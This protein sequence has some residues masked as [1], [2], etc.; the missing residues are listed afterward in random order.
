MQ[1]SIFR[2][3]FPNNSFPASA[4]FAMLYAVAMCLDGSKPLHVQP[5]L[6]PRMEV[7]GV[8]ILPA[9][10]AFFKVCPVCLVCGSP[11]MLQDFS[12]G[13]RFS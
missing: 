10:A 3:D 11:R 13:A 12:E 1:C 5:E 6:Q 4:V 9:V 7:A 8:N 2:I